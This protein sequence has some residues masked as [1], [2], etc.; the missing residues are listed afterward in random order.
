[1]QLSGNNIEEYRPIDCGNQS[2]DHTGFLSF[3]PQPALRKSGQPQH[4]SI[5]SI[6]SDADRVV[7]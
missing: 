1:M 2:L 3:G 7:D 5:G 4:D 6:K